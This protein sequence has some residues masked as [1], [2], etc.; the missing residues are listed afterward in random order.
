MPLFFIIV[1]SILSL[2]YGY[3]GWRFIIP[4]QLHPPWNWF[5]WAILIIF[6]I[7]P[8]I[9][10]FFRSSTQSSSWN[11]AL[12]WIA[13]LGMGFLFLL[14]TVLLIRDL[15]WLVVTAF[16]NSVLY[17]GGLLN[18]G[19]HHIVATDPARRRFLTNMMNLGV[20]GVAATLTAYGVYQARRRPAVVGIPIAIP[21]LPTDLHG[22]RIVQITDIHVG[23][24]VKKDWVETVVEMVNDLAPD[25]IVFTGDLA[26]G[27]VPRLRPEVLP[28][29]DLAA[30]HGCYFVTG[31]H[32]YYSGAE[33]WVEEIQ[34]LGLWILINEHRIIRE[35]NG[36]ILLAGITDYTG[37]QFLPSHK[38]DPR[39]AYAGAPPANVNILLAHQ[40]RS[41][42]E[43]AKI[44]F[45]LMISGHTHGGQFFPWNFLVPLEQP[46]LAGLHN[47]PVEKGEGYVYVSQ[48]TG[49]WGPP[50][51]LGTRSEI[52]VFTLLRKAEPSV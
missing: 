37:G 31:N 27:S 41:V 47:H 48:G 43:A 35:G 11:D 34:R 26:D 25:L 50:I 28:L 40:P 23:L 12:A 29:I 24:T 36:R 2:I 39:A 17:I 13:Y 3:I 45:D 6:L 10:L 15:G 46:Y 49:Y 44:G 30:P 18:S 8:F 5:A 16:R 1:I 20:L 14:F 21:E 7:L 4:A 52:T 42:F 38:S 19:A 22:F 32:E 33:A 51:R 9:S